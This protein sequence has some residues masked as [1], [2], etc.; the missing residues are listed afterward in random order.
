MKQIF[1]CVVFLMVLLIITPIKA[2][3][4]RKK[5]HLKG[6]GYGPYSMNNSLCVLA[7]RLGGG[8]NCHHSDA[9]SYICSQSKCDSNGYS[10]SG[11]P[12][13]FLKNC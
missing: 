5:E 4:L 1:L 13:V 7:C 2:I 10:L 6:N 12:I 11:V 8:T 3:S 9:T